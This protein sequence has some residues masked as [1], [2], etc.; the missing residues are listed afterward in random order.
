VPPFF[1][2]PLGIAAIVAGAIPLEAIYDD[3]HVSPYRIRQ[4][5]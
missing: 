4:D 1:L 3:I 2:A 5:Y